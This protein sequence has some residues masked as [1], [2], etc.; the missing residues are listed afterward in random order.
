MPVMDGFEA[1]REIRR[2]EDRRQKT[3]V[4]SQAKQR[5]SVDQSPIINHQSSIHRIPI[6]AMTADAMGGVR[7]KVIDAGMNAYVAKPINPGDLFR[8][9]VKCVQ[10][11]NRN[12]LSGISAA[13]P[14]SKGERSDAD[15]PDIL[16]GINIKEALNRVGGNKGLLRKLLTRFCAN[17]GSAVKEMVTAL[18]SADRKTA[19][20]LAHTLKG[21]SGNIGARELY[22]AAKKLEA[23]I[24]EEKEELSDLLEC[25]SDNLKIVISAIACVDESQSVKRPERAGEAVDISKVAPLLDELKTLLQENDIDALRKLD[26][27]KE[28]LNGSTWHDELTVVE[29]SLRKY[30]SDKALKELDGLTG[31]LKIN[32]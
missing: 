10:P 2:M 3:E 11:G 8:A 9:L 12:R 27:L 15:L 29:Q 32:R 7:A 17:H 13:T 31:R 4:G 30:D 14:D 21:V 28:V 18:E 24:N 20:R 25:V 26:Q 1:T 6:I 23:A 5:Q 16:P 22:E 19:S